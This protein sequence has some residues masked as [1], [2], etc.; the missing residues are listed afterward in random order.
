MTSD[1]MLSL[2][3]TSDHVG[4]RGISCDVS[5]SSC[6]RQPCR[7]ANAPKT[8]VFGLLQPLPGDFGR[9]TSLLG[10]FRSRDIISCLVRVGVLVLE[11]VGVLF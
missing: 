11:L 4:S 1:E 2:R 9:M 5:A 10:P 6:E 3:V 8:R 7:K